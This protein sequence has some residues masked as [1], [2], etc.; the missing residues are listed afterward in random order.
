MPTNFLGIRGLFRNLKETFWP[1]RSIGS[2]GETPRAQTEN[3]SNLAAFGAFGDDHFEKI[4]PPYLTSPDKSRLKEGLEQFNPENSTKE[5]KYDNFY[6]DDIDSYFKQSDLIAE[7][8][9]PEWDESHRQYNTLYGDAMLLSNTCDINP[10]NQRNANAKQSLF[11]P[12]IDLPEYLS[13][14]RRN[15]YS[16]AQ[17][18]TFEADIKRQRI[19]NILYLPPYK[20]NG[21]SY[22]VLLDYIFRF[23]TLELRGLLMNIAE[24]KIKSLSHFGYYLFI[25][26]LSYHLCRVPEEKER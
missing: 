24:E 12:I 17:M 14:L 7:V 1:R 5:I 23:P 9:F 13:D 18:Q 4:L 25:F 19:T 11:A 6:Q 16:D 3:N 2:P 22:I 20:A 10:D 26:K 15:G 8:R 21:P